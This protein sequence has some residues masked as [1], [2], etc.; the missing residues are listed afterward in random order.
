MLKSLGKDS[1]VTGYSL[2]RCQVIIPEFTGY[3]QRENFNISM[4]RDSSD[5]LNQV[6]QFKITSSGISSHY[7]SLIGA[8]ESLHCCKVFLPHSWVWSSRQTSP[9]LHR[10]YAVWMHKG[11]P[12]MMRTD[13]SRTWDV[14]QDHSP[15]SSKHPLSPE[16]KKIRETVLDVK[17]QRYNQAIWCVKLI[18]Y[19]MRKKSLKIFLGKFENLNMEWMLSDVMKPM[20]LSL[21][22]SFGFIMVLQSLGECLYS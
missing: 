6:I 17:V 7:L 20:L 21:A 1:R 10:K 16:K 18:Q 8:M 5:H 3:L 2:T 15:D 14:L 9:P 22:F 13:K 19:C 11:N 4:E 12:V